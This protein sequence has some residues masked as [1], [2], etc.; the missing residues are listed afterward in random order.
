MR[1]NALFVPGDII[2]IVSGKF[3]G[4]VQMGVGVGGSMVLFSHAN[5]HTFLNNR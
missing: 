3:S 1:C 4:S 5:S 2:Y